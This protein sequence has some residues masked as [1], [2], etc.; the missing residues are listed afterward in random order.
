MKYSYCCP[1]TN[2]ETYYLGQVKW[3]YQSGAPSP[4]EAASYFSSSFGKI[5]VKYVQMN[6]SCSR[7]LR[8]K[9]FVWPKTESC[10]HW[11]QYMCSSVLY[12]CFFFIQIHFS[13]GKIWEIFCGHYH[14]KAK[15]Q[16][17]EHSYVVRHATANSSCSCAINSYSA[18]SS[19]N[20]MLLH[21][22]QWTS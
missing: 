7:S 22:V 10:W 6:G 5:F 13:L 11:S 17:S 20:K 18:Y 14:K 21:D 2:I 3:S 4:W 15:E 1:F 12:S 16:T 8:A 9:N 19:K